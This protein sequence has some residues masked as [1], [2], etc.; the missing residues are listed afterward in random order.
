MPVGPGLKSDRLVPESGG[1]SQ[2][3]GKTPMVMDAHYG[4]RHGNSHDVR[5]ESVE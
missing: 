5:I 4:H 3:K 2:K 1:G